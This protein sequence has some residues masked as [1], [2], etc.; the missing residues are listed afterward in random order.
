MRHRDVVASLASALSLA[1]GA[2]SALAQGPTAIYSSV[3]GQANRLVP[4]GGGLLFTSLDRPQPSPSGDR[5]IVLATNDSGNTANDRMY[6]TGQRDAGLLRIR[7]GVTEIEPGR[8]AEN[9]SDRRAGITDDGRFGVSLNLTGATTDDGVGVKGTSGGALSVA[10]REGQTVPFFGGGITFGPSI[11]DVGM[12]SDGTLTFRATSLGGA[13]S[14]NN[15]ALLRADGGSLYARTGVTFPTGQTGTS[16]AVSSF[17]FGSVYTSSSSSFVLYKADLAGPAATNQVLVYGNSVVIQ[18]GVTISSL[19]SPVSNIITN[20]MT[21]DATWY[22]RGENANDQAWVMRQGALIA[23][24][25]ASVP[26][27]ITGETWSNSVW[28]VSNGNTFGLN[29]GNHAGDFIVGGFT[30]NPDTARQYALVLNNTQVVL[31]E[32]DAIDLNGDGLFNDDAFYYVTGLT[33]ASLNNKVDNFFLTDDLWLYGV[34]DL[35]NGA[36][37]A[38]GEAFIRIQVPTPGGV[39]VAAI[40]AMVA[41]RRRR[42]R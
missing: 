13:G 29:T 1:A 17:S 28:N 7:E 4:G 20:T 30:S 18:E 25:G 34:V 16:Q 31:R 12:S 37:A 11:S 41:G 22:A 15:A 23:Q 36:G 32:G 33:G 42:S 19:A 5:W 10:F 2:T 39:A 6:L 8:V 24:S 14:G 9:M 3:V 38:I 26:G 40:A 21:A 27:G 35:R